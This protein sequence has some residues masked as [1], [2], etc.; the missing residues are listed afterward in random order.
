MG[1]L[2]VFACK[3][4]ELDP[5]MG[6]VDDLF[7]WVGGNLT[8]STIHIGGVIDLAKHEHSLSKWPTFNTTHWYKENVYIC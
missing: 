8:Y 1:G 2:G 6:L 7:I 5:N 3:K 4:R